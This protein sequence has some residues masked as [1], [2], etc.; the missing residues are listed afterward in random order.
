[1]NS[2]LLVPA[3]VVVALAAM[4]AVFFGDVF[5]GD[6]GSSH[7]DYAVAHTEANHKSMASSDSEAAVD[8]AKATE[9][10][11]N[12]FSW[13]EDD[14]SNDKREPIDSFAKSGESFVGAKNSDEAPG[15]VFSTSKN[16]N[17]KGLSDVAKGS[18]NVTEDIASDSQVD[19]N[20][21][22]DVQTDTKQVNNDLDSFFN[23]PKG[24]TAKPTTKMVDQSTV[25]K[26]MEEDVVNVFVSSNTA[27]KSKE[28]M[29]GDF[30]ESSTVATPKKESLSMDNFA[31]GSD[32]RHEETIENNFVKESASSST[33]MTEST[34][35]NLQ[36]VVSTKPSGSSLKSATSQ[37]QDVGDDVISG[38]LEPVV[39][40]TVNQA[41]SAS[42]KTVRKFKITNPKETTLP[43]TLSV[44]GEQITLKPDQTYVIRDHDGMVD[45][46]YSRGGSFGFENKSLKSGHY[47]FSV[48]RESGWK[49]NN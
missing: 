29:F 32:S 12:D 35:D 11:A 8:A 44:D 4:G 3:F 38:N 25:S 27:E 22:K 36:S 26:P 23:L 34:S 41:K 43:V 24:S 37:M 7:S 40:S 28:S 6:A 49:L 20:P 21:S 2:S 33:K 10:M 15:D 42:K 16:G 14:S 18:S 39:D 46:T 9:S 1:M 30:G 31:A 47:R 17:S 5:T 48:T 13:D 45:V 19:L